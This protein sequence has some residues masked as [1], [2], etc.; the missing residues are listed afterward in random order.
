MSR[1]TPV[2]VFGHRLRQARS[3][4]RIPQDQ[5]GVQI[6]LEES[7]ASAR[8][9]RYETGVHEPPF[10]TAVRLAA[11]LSV[12][13]AYLFCEDDELAALLLVWGRLNKSERK[14]AKSLLE[15]EFGARV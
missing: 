8:M 3:L 7:S 14:R 6:G 10:E 11:A 12:P 5:L 9:S 4:A 2:S 13:T 1:K 15:S